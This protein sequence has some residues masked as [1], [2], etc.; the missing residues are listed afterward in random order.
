MCLF[1]KKNKRQ[2][3]KNLNR[4]VKK[5]SPEVRKAR[6]YLEKLYPELPRKIIFE[7]DTTFNFIEACLYGEYI[8]YHFCEGKNDRIVFI[9]LS[10]EELEKV[11]QLFNEKLK[12]KVKNVGDFK[13]MGSL[14][15]MF[16]GNECKH[17]FLCDN[18]KLLAFMSDDGDIDFPYILES[19]DMD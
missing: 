17:R 2:D 13:Y 9:V 6:K 3:D 14:K 10:D 12:E 8:R 15:G 11:I 16:V 19:E 1:C 18:S 5:S 4:K 7:K